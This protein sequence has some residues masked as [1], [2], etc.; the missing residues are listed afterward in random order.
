M[1]VPQVT[2]VNKGSS[3]QKHLQIKQKKSKYAPSF[4]FYPVDFVELTNFCRFS[5]IPVFVKS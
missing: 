1:P 4:S 3:A 2:T 5:K